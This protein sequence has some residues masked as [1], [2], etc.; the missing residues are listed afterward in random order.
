[1]ALEKNGWGEKLLRQVMVVL[2]K[3]GHKF[4]KS[5]QNSGLADLSFFDQAQPPDGPHIYLGVIG[6]VFTP[7][8]LPPSNMGEIE[9]TL[10]PYFEAGI[11]KRLLNK[12]LSRFETSY[13]RVDCPNAKAELITDAIE[14][15]FL[16]YQKIWKNLKKN[17]LKI[18]RD[19]VSLIE[20]YLNAAE[21]G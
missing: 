19:F 3:R 2:E 21:K 5:K 16:Y 14:Q 10:W 8:I 18:E 1:M 7:V 17:K 4:L 11:E 6:N 15:H 12:K 9:T 13:N 20:R